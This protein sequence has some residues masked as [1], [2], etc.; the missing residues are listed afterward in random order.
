MWPIK[1]LLANRSLAKT[2]APCRNKKEKKKEEEE[3]IVRERR[4]EEKM[5]KANDNILKV[6][7]DSS[8]VTYVQTSK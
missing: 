6:H 8:K 1:S 2:S 4:R 3:A 7:Y 5:E